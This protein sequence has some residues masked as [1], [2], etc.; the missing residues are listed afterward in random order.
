M[1]TYKKLYSETL[2]RVFND[3][4]DRET[5]EAHIEKPKQEAHGDL[6]FPCFS[7]ARAYKKA[8][9]QI[10]AEAARQLSDSAFAKFEA[11]GPYLNAFIDRN[12]ASQTII[13]EVLEKGNAFGDQSEGV[14]KTITFDLSAPNIAKPFSMGHLR[15]TVVGNAIANLAEKCGYHTVRINYIGDWGTQFGKQIA[16]YKKWGDKSKVLANPIEELFK[17]YTRFHEEADQNPALNDEGRLW[18][19]KLEDGDDEAVQLWRWFR[20]VSLKAFDKIYRLLGVQFD[21]M[22]GESFYNDKM[23]AVVQELE[24]KGLL[25]ES[26]GAMVVR[27][28]DEDLPPCLI[29]KKDG[30][31]LYATRDL[32]SAI[33]RKQTYHFDQA[34]YVVGNEQSLHFA[35]LKWVLEK[36]GYEWAKDIEHVPFGMVLK[37]GKK[38]STRKGKV[39][40]LED[41]LKNIIER[42]KTSILEKNP[43]LAQKDE[44]ATQVGVG[45]VIYHDLKHYRINDVEFS[46]DDMLRFEGNTGP[47]LQYTHARAFSILRKAGAVND[48]ELSGMTDDRS[49]QVVTAIAAFPDDIRLAFKD[50]NPAQ[51]AKSLFRV[52][53]SFN[54]YYAHERILGA[55][56]QSAKC[57]LTQAVVVVIKEGLRILGIQ[58][59]EEM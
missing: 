36:M 4:L 2:Y 13:H 25:V 29:M 33:Y 53:Q 41:V 37:D 57:A 30:A 43:D 35:Q 44:V 58:A 20:E 56:D 9:Q 40:L 22:N 15:S 42:A 51:I 46:L 54:Q 10:A 27:L 12:K 49:W 24:A 34:L 21:S 59:P 47:Y 14:G 45:A 28:D 52:A 19:K 48:Y 3:A 39:V 17:L 26:E 55:D 1:N 32:A 6:A 16:A 7:L 18:F 5:I 50:R 11:N 31:T 23:D 8:P 38:M